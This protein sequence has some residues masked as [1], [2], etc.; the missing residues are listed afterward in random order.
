MSESEQTETSQE[1]AAGAS[2]P[3]ETPENTAD[4]TQNTPEVV[5]YDFRRANRISKDQLSSLRFVCERV[6]NHLGIALSAFLRSSC[7]VG[8]SNVKP[9]SYSDFVVS[10]P[11]TAAVWT[12]SI[13]PIS[14]TGILELDAASV[15]GLVHTMLGGTGTATI[16]DRPLTEIEQT[17]A[18]NATT[19]ILG[20]LKQEWKDFKEIDFTLLHW[21]T[22]PQML[23][24]AGQNEPFAVVH[25][26]MTL[27]EST[28]QL[29]LGLPSSALQDMG[30]TG[31]IG[32]L[33]RRSQDTT[34]HK[35]FLE[36]LGKMP[37]EVTAS[38]ESS[39]PAAEV[40]SLAVNDT[41]SLGTPATAPAQL[42][43]AGAP[44]YSG[45]LVAQENRLCFQVDSALAPE[46]SSM[47][48]TR[49]SE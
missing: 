3:T 10:V 30:L 23:N 12:V 47:V 36:I 22:K 16:I 1:Q 46:P 17:V 8:L 11:E 48:D 29:L 21:T 28:G 18:A 32:Q 31:N 35:I 25:F 9:T 19:I 26:D 7:S 40:V 43:V 6:A 45:R 13:E 39:I 44:K 24:V 49:D 41:I 42:K 14:G 15:Y 34:E 20:V 5:D 27:G 38:V 4:T 33:R 2:A 37:L